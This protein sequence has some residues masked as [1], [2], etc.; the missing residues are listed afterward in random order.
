MC[1][2]GQTPLIL[3]SA[4]K[5]HI[6]AKEYDVMRNERIIILDPRYSK[7]EDWVEAT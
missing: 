6:I 1:E 7:P 4:S 2:Y 3:V 5:H